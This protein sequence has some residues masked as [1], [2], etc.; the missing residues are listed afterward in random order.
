MKKPWIVLGIFLA[1][2]AAF[3]GDVI[4]R[5]AA[6]VN[7]EIILLSEVDEKLFL[8]QA[9][10]Q[11]QGVKAE[12]LDGRR[13]D[14][15]DRLIEEKLVVQRAKSQG[16]TLDESEVARAVQ[17]AIDRVKGQFPSEDAFRQALEAEGITLTMLRER[18]EHDIR[19][20]R[21]VQRIVGREIR[22]QV[23]VDTEEARRYYQDHKADLPKKPQ[24]IRLA[25]LV[26][27][28]ISPEREGAAVEQIGAAYEDLLAGAPFDS[29]IAAYRGGRLGRFCPGDLDPGVEAVLDTLPTGSFSEPVRSLQGYHIF[30]MLERDGSC[31]VL[32]HILVAVPMEEEDIELAR[33]KADAAL[34]RIRAG[35]EFETVVRE[36]SDD[37]MT[38]DIGGDLGWTASEGLVPAVTDAIDSL[39]IGAISGVV[40]TERGFHVFKL[41]DRREGGEYDFD[42]IRER[43][44]GFLEQQELEEAYG[45]WLASVRDSAFVEVKTWS[46]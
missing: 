3:A 11:L 9:Q 25:H 26:A 19:Q 7:E 12:E 45:K 16:I 32:R 17:E 2:G 29:V 39:Q 33:R 41:L 5:I 10:G 31:W 4:D 6:V 8:L 46:R 22:S 1:S 28:P 40:Q 34:M 15:L 14:I 36:V 24:E 27:Q 23:E 44:I 38:R 43:L 35:E 21:Y 18:Y 37:P 42:E 13:R 30:D 20:E